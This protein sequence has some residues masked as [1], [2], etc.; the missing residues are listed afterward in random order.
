MGRQ[1]QIKEDAG[2]H[3][4]RHQDSEQTEGKTKVHTRE[5]RGTEDRKLAARRHANIKHGTN[6]GLSVKIPRVSCKTV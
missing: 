5:V 1:P 6:L 4:Q 2:V 3:T